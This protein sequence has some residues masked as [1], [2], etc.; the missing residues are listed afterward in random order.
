MMMDGGKGVK[1]R[2]IE[3]ILREH[4]LNRATVEKLKR[5]IEYLVEYLGGLEHEHE[6]VLASF[7]MVRSTGV[8]VY[9]PVEGHG[10]GHTSDP[11]HEAMMDHLRAVK[12]IEKTQWETRKELREKRQAVKDLRLRGEDVGTALSMVRPDI[13]FALEQRYQPSGLSISEI[14]LSIPRDES[15]LREHMNNALREIE[16]YLGYLT[17]VPRISPEISPKIP[18]MLPETVGNFSVR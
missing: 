18:R 2:H 16:Q 10:A 9:A 5:Q 17:G 7:K 4:F 12:E 8:A 1:N 13:R 11:T 15:T 6:Q 3:E 14:A